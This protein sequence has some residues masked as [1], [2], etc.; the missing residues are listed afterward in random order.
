MGIIKQTQEYE[1]KCMQTIGMTYKGLNILELGNQIIK[2]LNRMPSKEWYTSKGAKHTSIDL[3]GLDGAL[4]LDLDKPLPESMNSKYDLVTNHGTTEHVDNQY[5][6][7]KNIHNACRNG[8]LMVHAVPLREH[9]DKHCRWYYM[10]E[11]FYDLAKAC[12]YRII[13]I[14]VTSTSDKKEDLVLS[15]FV[16]TGSYFPDIETFNSLKG[17]YDSGRTN[18]SGDYENKFLL[19]KKIKRFFLN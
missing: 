5:Q 10:E 14:H 12:N 1:S 3:N 8:G 16:K 9:W 7:F 19:L 11:F 17:L 2:H 13:N 4:K 15:A 18:R 6:V